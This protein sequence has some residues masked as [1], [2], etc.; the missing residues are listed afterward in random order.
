MSHPSNK[1]AFLADGEN[2]SHLRDLAIN[3]LGAEE[4]YTEPGLFALRLND[5]NV[6]ELYG[7][8]A[9]YPGYLFRQS[10]VVVSFQ[11]NDLEAATRKAEKAGFRL[12]SGIQEVCIG[13]S[14]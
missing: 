5:G 2:I 8:G 14:Y 1:I 13:F 7:T 6:L 3:V 11:V 12:L 10:K 9:C 4:I